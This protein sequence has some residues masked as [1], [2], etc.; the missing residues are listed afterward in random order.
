MKTILIT[1][2]SRGIGAEIARSAFLSGEYNVIINY[3]K[4]GAR[5][6]MLQKELEEISSQNKDEKFGRV[7]AVGAD[8]SRE[9]EVN[10]LFD[11]A[12]KTFGKVDVLVN[13]AAVSSYSLFQ[14]LTLEAWHETM[15]TNLDSVFLC[16]K[17]ALPRMI[18]EKC[19]RI[20]NISSI[21]GICGSSCEVHYSTSKAAIIGLTKALAKEVGPS[22]IT[23]N[24][25]AP[26]VIDTEMNKALSD[27]DRKA[28]CDET[29]LGCIGKCEDIAKTVLF[30][31]GD[32]GDFITG[33]V[34][35]PNGG[36]VI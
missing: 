32:G 2:S 30:L 7:L 14:D 34:I 27:D 26:G 22:G 8:V 20:I 16:T 1:G 29:P 31:A 13:N 18:S 5:A 23:V 6:T 12:E 33:Q 9:D 24:C 3:N 36:I 11:T 19:G 25:V 35:S 4:S 10:S 28:L 21:W 17:R 15:A